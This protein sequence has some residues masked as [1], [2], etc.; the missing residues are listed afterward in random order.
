M[1]K[2]IFKYEPLYVARAETPQFDERFIGFGMTRNTQ[3]TKS[4]WNYQIV[5]LG[6]F[7]L[8][9]ILFCSPPHWSGVW[10]VRSWLQVPSPQQCF[11]IPLGIPGYSL[12]ILV[13]KIFYKIF[14]SLKSRPAW[15][16]KQQEE[17]NARFDEFAREVL[18]SFHT[19]LLFITNKLWLDRG[20]IILLWLSAR[21]LYYFRKSSF[22]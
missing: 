19:Y 11:H 3:V 16:A 8:I 6:I 20:S 22:L 10:D 21:G 17:N 18:T 12:T 5:K 14:Q 9:R 13:G 7:Q 4:L 2:Y 1:E 15:R